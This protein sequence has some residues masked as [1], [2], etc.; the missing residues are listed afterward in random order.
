MTEFEDVFS[1]PE[2]LVFP[3]EIN[4]YLTEK[5]TVLVHENG[6]LRRN[7][8]D[9]E[10]KHNKLEKQI[11]DL[12]KQLKSDESSPILER[13]NKASN[14]INTKIV[15][16]SKNLREKCA[17]LETYKT[18]CSKL[19]TCIEE[20]KK[21]E[22]KEE[23]IQEVRKEPES[24]S[25]IKSLQDRLNVTMNKLMEA[26]NANVQLKNDLKQANKF[27]QQ[28][29]GENFE[30]L[31]S[32]GNWKGRAQIICDLQEKNK[33]LKEKLSESRFPLKT[34][35]SLERVSGKIASLEK[36]IADLK[37]TNENYR[38]RLETLKSRCMMLEAEKQDMKTKM[39]R[40]EEENETSADSAMDLSRKLSEIESEKKRMQKKW[41][42]E[43]AR[44]KSEISRLLMLN[45]KLQELLNGS[46]ERVTKSKQEPCQSRSSYSNLCQS[47]RLTEQN[48]TDRLQLAEENIKALQ[49]KLAMEQFEK[50]EDFQQFS[51]ILR[52]CKLEQNE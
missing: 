50:E 26:K 1:I 52:L 16:L 9:H 31:Q 7:I 36:E 33:K 18:K 46:K 28:E 4:E 47:S 40:L 37:T 5:V 8:Q 34:T 15:E 42:D 10:E 19:L 32:N 38:T 12:S 11:K 2:N 21:N 29:V 35:P 51:K 30:T 41:E 20:L 43:D 6:M 25:E 39:G 3:K 14:A 27:L 13:V 24:K 48:L 44:A 22:T 17:E 49:A 45:G 23:I